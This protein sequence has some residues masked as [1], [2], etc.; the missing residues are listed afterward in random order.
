[1]KVILNNYKLQSILICF[2]LESS[3]KKE[4]INQ[5][6]TVCEFFDYVPVNNI[7]K[8]S[9]YFYNFTFFSTFVQFYKI[10]VGGFFNSHKKSCII[11]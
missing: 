9:K 8:K 4:K 1:M 2:F 3:Q 5:Q 11:H 7:N 10:K 6:T